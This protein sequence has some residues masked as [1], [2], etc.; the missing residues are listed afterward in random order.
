MQ[1]FGLYHVQPFLAV[2]A[3]VNGYP[4]ENNITVM[5]VFF[6]NCFEVRKLFLARPAPGGPYIYEYNLPFK[7]FHGN[8]A[9]GGIGQ[10]EII[11][12]FTYIGRIAAELVIYF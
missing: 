1:I 12:R 11:S 9:A 7:I 10:A 8:H 2:P 3:A 4:H 6:F 5:L